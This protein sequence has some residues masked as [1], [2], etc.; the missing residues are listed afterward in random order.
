MKLQGNAILVLP[1]KLPEKTRTGHLII[2][3]SSK[4][5]ISEWGNVVDAGPTCKEVKKGMRVLFPRKQA[6]L[7]TID[8]VDYYFINEHQ[9]RY[10]E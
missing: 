6:S 2:P 10:C 7:I 3:R 4:E 8:R 9:I 5:M 1:D